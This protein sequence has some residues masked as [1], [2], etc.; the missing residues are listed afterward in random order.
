MRSNAK[1]SVASRCSQN[2]GLMKA[3]GKKNEASLLPSLESMIHGGRNP[4]VQG[5]ETG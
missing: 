4:D 3:G 2:E 5:L 1:P